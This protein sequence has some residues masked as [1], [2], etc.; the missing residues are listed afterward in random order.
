MDAGSGRPELIHGEG[1]YRTTYYY[2]VAGTGEAFLS[3][4][5]TAHGKTVEAVVRVSVDAD[6][7]RTPHLKQVMAEL[8]RLDDQGRTPTIMDCSPVHEPAW[9]TWELTGEPCSIRHHKG[10]Q[11]GHW[12][13]E[14]GCRHYQ[15]DGS[16]RLVSTRIPGGP[17]AHFAYDERD[18]VASIA[19]NWGDVTYLVRD[20]EN[21]EVSLRDN[22]DV[23]RL[24]RD[25]AGNTRVREYTGPH[26]IAYT[27]R[28]P[29]DGKGQDEPRVVTQSIY[30][31]LLGTM[32]RKI[33]L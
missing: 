18:R 33:R 11:D 9:E 27:F 4:I 26:A 14:R 5:K 32:E 29:G 3:G 28:E 24:E 16:G 22:H 21:G 23:A 17:E 13:A 7:V 30:N 6:G 25:E 8:S 10:R 19:T 15:H 2:S 20:D 12:Q 1:G 31:P